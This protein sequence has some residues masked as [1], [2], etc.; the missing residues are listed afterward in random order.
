M[1]DKDSMSLVNRQ[2]AAVDSVNPITDHRP[3]L[4]RP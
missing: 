1:F 3:A 4:R 2:G